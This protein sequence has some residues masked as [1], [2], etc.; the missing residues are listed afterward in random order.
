MELRAR[1]LD[2]DQIAAVEQAGCQGEQVAGEIGGAE[3]VAAAHQQD[4]ARESH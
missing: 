1:P 3:I 2:E 4:R